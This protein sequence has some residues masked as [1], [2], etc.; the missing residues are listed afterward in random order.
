[1]RIKQ[2]RILILTKTKEIQFIQKM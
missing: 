2:W 1:M